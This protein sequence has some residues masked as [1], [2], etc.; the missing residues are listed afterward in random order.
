MNKKMSVGHLF[1]RIN[2]PLNIVSSLHTDSCPN[3]E[4]IITESVNRAESMLII[5]PHQPMLTSKL[6]LSLVPTAVMS[7]IAHLRRRMMSLVGTIEGS[8]PNLHERRW[9]GR[10]ISKSFDIHRPSS[11]RNH[12]S[13]LLR[14]K[15][16]KD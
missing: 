3:N 9:L 8:S 10:W 12:M 2:T 7:S 15:R 1:R 16:R 13:F 14:R 11:W 6:L 5:L 4:L